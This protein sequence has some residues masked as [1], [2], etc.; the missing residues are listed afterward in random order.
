MPQSACLRL[1]QFRLAGLVL[2]AIASI[3]IFAGSARGQGTSGTL[4]DPI[5]ARELT[6]YEDRLQLSPQQR[7]A[8]ETFH[9]QYKR[10][11]R[12]LREGEIAD[13]LKEMR[14][15]NSA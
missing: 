10:E 6:R 11:F 7:Q 1:G 8:A 3:L 12:A 9:E 13:F 15:L 4:P 14:S 2:G 5:S